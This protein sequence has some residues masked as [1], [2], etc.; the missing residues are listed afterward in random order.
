VINITKGRQKFIE[1]DGSKS[2]R[3]PTHPNF[4]T[5][6]K[7]KFLNHQDLEVRKL[8]EDLP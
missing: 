7:E 2:Y 8:A 5:Y 6:D 1:N 3:I 4:V